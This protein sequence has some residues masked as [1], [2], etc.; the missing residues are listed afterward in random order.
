MSETLFKEWRVSFSEIANLF[1]A[2]Q[3]FK[4]VFPVRDLTA[5]HGREPAQCKMG[6]RT[7]KTTRKE[8]DFFFE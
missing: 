6:E 3:Q 4:C 7:V 5:A 2:A 8:E 1:A